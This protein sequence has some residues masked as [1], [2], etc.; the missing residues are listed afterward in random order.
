MMCVCVYKPYLAKPLSGNLWFLHF[1]QSWIFLWIISR[2]SIVYGVVDHQCES[3][4]MPLW[5]LSHEQSFSTS[6]V[7]IFHL[8]SLPY[9]CSVRVCVCLCVRVS[10][11]VCRYPTLLCK[12][13]WNMCSLYRLFT[14]NKNWVKGIVAGIITISGISAFLIQYNSSFLSHIL[15]LKTFYASPN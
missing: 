5:K 10:V 8:K 15:Q 3:T 9:I 1:T 4:S 14:V 6:T 2:C 7:K 11:C 12:H 13:W